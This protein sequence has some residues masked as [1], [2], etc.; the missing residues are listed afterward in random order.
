MKVT[1]E[2]DVNGILTVTAVDIATGNSNN[3]IIT[4]DT[5]RLSK[6][7]IERMI[8]EAEKFRV[9]FLILFEMGL[10]INCGIFFWF[11]HSLSRCNGFHFG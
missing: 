8:T 9:R 5:G 11:P 3:I 2:L 1:F 4:N 10:S 7:Q 6:Q